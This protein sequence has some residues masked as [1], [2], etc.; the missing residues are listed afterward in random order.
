[1]AVTLR[2][3]GCWVRRS[4]AQAGSNFSI[5]GVRRSRKQFEMRVLSRAWIS[6]PSRNP[7]L[8]MEDH[9]RSQSPREVWRML[10]VYWEAFGCKSQKSQPKEALLPRNSMSPT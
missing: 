5:C 3:S 6:N 4:W 10:P 2:L 8:K 1:M 7:P 9:R